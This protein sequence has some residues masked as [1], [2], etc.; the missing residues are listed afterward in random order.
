M[1]YQV[2]KIEKNY[3][4]VHNFESLKPAEDMFVIFEEEAIREKEMGFEITQEIY[5]T[6]NGRI[7]V[8][9]E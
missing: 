1:K 9:W 6:E 7:I 5:L 2:I 3:I 4:G 8:S